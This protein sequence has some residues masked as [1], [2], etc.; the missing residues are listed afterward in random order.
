MTLSRR[1]F[2]TSMGA[3]AV[4]AQL[5]SRAYA[6]AANRVGLKDYYANDF[7][8]GT[9][10]GGKILGGD[11]ELEA[12]LIREFS[13]TTPENC[14]KW[15]SIRTADNGWN[16]RDADTYVDL[17]TRN[18][19]YVVGHCLAWH[20][21]IP[22][23][24]FK[25]ASGDYISAEALSKKMHE[26]ISTLVGRYKGRINAWDAVNEA[27]GDG[28]G[29][30]LRTSHYF[31][32]LGEQFIDLAFNI[33]HE[34]DPNVH[35]IYNDYGIER[36]GKREACIDLI[37]RL[38][39]RGVPVNGIGIQAHISI[40]EPDIADIEKSI[41]DFAAL[42]L[43]VHFT[44]LDIDVLPNVWKLP[45]ADVSTRFEYKPERD[46]YI[47]GLPK[48]IEDK[49]ADRWESLFKVFIKHR[50]KIQRVTT[51][52]ISDDDSWLNNFPIR[53]RTNYPLLFDRKHQ[54]HEAYFKL[55]DLKK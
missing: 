42:E 9:A 15:A 8:I 41:V 3:S 7:K 40:D 31:N 28:N 53:G 46:P 39:K 54:P 34:T 38:Q 37:K 18:N 21:Q 48:E 43:R 4:L 47:K 25:N 2:I 55:I 23:S 26:H 6:E 22:D 5:T 11:K 14:L 51:W 49:L 29:N 30:P 45:V 13:S 16:W 10:V 1:T 27:I 20:S 36:S 35:L 33:A 52:G 44:E 32:I 19:M 17:G 12:I 50:D 24:V